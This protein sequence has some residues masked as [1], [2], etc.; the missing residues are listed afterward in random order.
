MN[1]SNLVLLLLL[2]LVFSSP[3]FAQETSPTPRLPQGTDDVDVVRVT[4]TV[5]TVPVSVMD[6]QGRF[7]PDLRKED[8]RIY[9]EGI[10]QE[11]A[12]FETADQMFTVALLLDT[13]DSTKFKIR[14]IQD[15]AIVFLNQLRPTDQVVVIAFDKNVYLMTE[16]TGNRDEIESAIRSAHAGGGTGLYNAVAAAI[17][18]RLDKIRGR[19]ALVLFTDG[20]DTESRGASYES[21]LRAAEELDA[22]VYSIQY[23]TDRDVAKGRADDSSANG[24]Y[25]SGVQLVTARGEPLDVAYKRGNLYLRMLAEK[26]GGR[27]F[28]AASPQNLSESFARIAAE[29]RQQYSLGYYPKDRS[30]EG[31]RRRLK[32]RVSKPDVVVRARKDYVFRP[33][34]ER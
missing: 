11:V 2:S 20:V 3:L 4:T 6:R 30:T 32:V 29:L 14:D 25:G 21:T 24:L 8:F 28:Y 17:E 15:A 12:F 22:L 7:I 18:Q 10:E 19:K 16:P 33:K 5:V 23:K 26:T 31:K 9:D 1:K 27:F 34:P 13:S